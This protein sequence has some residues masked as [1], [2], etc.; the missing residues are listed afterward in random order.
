MTEKYKLATPLIEGGE[1]R[2][3]IRLEDGACIPMDEGNHDYQAYLV[4]VAE[5]N[6]PLPADA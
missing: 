1:S 6:K 2:G 3:I 5:G 4:W